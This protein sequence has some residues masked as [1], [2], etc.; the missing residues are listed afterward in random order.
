MIFLLPTNKGDVHMVN[1]VILNDYTLKVT[2]YNEEVVKNE[3]TGNE[4]KKISFDFKVRGG[5]EYHDV[6]SLLYKNTFD[7]KVP[8]KNLEFRGTIHN[9]Y[10]SRGN[11]SD[12]N[13]VADFKLE[14]IEVE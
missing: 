12:E 14:L 2:D 6:T 11:F 9:Y 8:E 1:E 7:V 10:T 13:V 4:L 3:K 5:D